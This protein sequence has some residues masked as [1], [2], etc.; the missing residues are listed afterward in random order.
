MSCEL[1]IIKFKLL[2]ESYRSSTSVQKIYSNIVEWVLKNSVNNL[3]L[4]FKYLIKFIKKTKKKN[5]YFILLSLF[6][7]WRISGPVYITQNK[8]VY[9]SVIVLVYKL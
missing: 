4:N 1:G 9:I 5:D 3:V 8:N 2:D 6:E 7:S